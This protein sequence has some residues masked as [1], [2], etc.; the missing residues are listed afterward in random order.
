MK[1]AMLAG[2]GRAGATLF[3]AV[4]S[5]SDVSGL[6]YRGDGNNDRFWV[7]YQVNGKGY[8]Y[9]MQHDLDDVFLLTGSKGGDIVPSDMVLATA[10]VGTYNTASQPNTY[11][12]TASDSFKL[13]FVGAQLSFVSFRDNRGGVWRFTIDAGLSGEQ[14]VDISTWAAVSV[15]PSTDLPGATQA[16][17]TGLTDGPHTCSAVFTGADPLH[18]PTGGI[19]R[20]WIYHRVSGSVVYAG[21]TQ[22]TKAALL[23]QTGSF[24][25]MAADSVFEAAIKSKPTGEVTS[26]DWVLAHEGR[27]GAARSVVKTITADGVSLGSDPSG[28]IARR[29]VTTLVVTQTYE[30]YSTFDVPGSF[31]L[32]DGV[33]TH[34]FDRNGLTVEHTISMARA[35]DCSIGYF[36]PMVAM[37]IALTDTI[38]Y[39]NGFSDTI[40][41]QPGTVD[42][43]VPGFP[44]EAALYDAS[45][46]FGVAYKVEG[47]TDAV[48]PAP[49]AGA[50]FFQERGS[51]LAKAYWIR[52]NAETIPADGEY[53]VRAIYFPMAAVDVATLP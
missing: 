3:G 45:T 22:T 50:V 30:A 52:F 15:N 38:K 5:L 39:S 41:I 36:A 24:D 9:R 33:L 19:A 43:A 4:K 51:T 16:V 25:V 6:Y 48:G 17:I 1:A 20:G 2:L 26:E 32:W 46:G 35:A 40:Q 23:N 14:V 42:T 8:E 34:T 49:L 44:N 31:K 29:P 18:A 10:L 28:F 13:D 12:T 11:T 7:G 37:N 53:S 21:R 27:S 47:I